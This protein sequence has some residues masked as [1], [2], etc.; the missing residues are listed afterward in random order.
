MTTILASMDNSLLVLDS[1]K[2]GWRVDEHLKQHNPNTLA[3]DPQNHDR[4]YCGTFDGG[5]WKT[6][7]NCQTWERISLTISNA[8]ITSVSV[9]PIEKG[10]GEFNRLF[11]GTEPSVIYSSSDG[12]QTWERFDEFKKLP[13]SSTWS[14][15]P[16]PTT[17]HVRWIEPD[18]NNE[19]Y[20][21]VAI[22]AD[23]LIRSFDG[24]KSWIDRVENGPYDT[25]M[26]R[27]HKKHPNRLYSAAGDGYFESRN[28]GDTW[29]NSSE[30][31]GYDTYLADIAIK[32]DD[33][34][35]I[36]V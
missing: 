12:G 1:T 19:K 13:S 8:N 7:D 36:V 14:F 2:D 5:L 24:G 4:A 21:F 27:T 20:V 23:A 26:L 18:A 6:N 16:R 31:L 32:S 3:Y 9:G 11:V 29:K 25:H 35:N 17:N 34:Q 28:Y 15:P 10:E 30:G 33:S 22:E